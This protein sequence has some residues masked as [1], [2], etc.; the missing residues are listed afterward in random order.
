MI[1]EIFLNVNSLHFLY[2]N[3]LPK[4]E[5]IDFGGYEHFTNLSLSQHPSLMYYVF[6]VA[7]VHVSKRDEINASTLI[8]LCLYL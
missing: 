3:Y 4:S 7:H 5:E 2:L 1:F 6:T 8:I